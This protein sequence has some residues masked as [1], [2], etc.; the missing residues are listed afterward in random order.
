MGLKNLTQNST[1]MKSN[2][3]YIPW[4]REENKAKFPWYELEQQC[5]EEN[6]N[7]ARIVLPGEA[8][9]TLKESFSGSATRN[10]IH[11]FLSHKRNNPVILNIY[12]LSCRE[13]ADALLRLKEEALEIIAQVNF[14]H[15]NT[16]PLHSIK[17][18]DWATSDLENMLDEDEYLNGIP[19]KVF[20]RLMK[21]VGNS[22]IWSWDPVQLIIL[23]QKFKSCKI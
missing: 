10:K 7:F 18:M 20:E 3:I 17:V 4:Y 16:N 1:I 2:I 21:P 15:P 6:K 23:M 8:N 14:L 22:D 12:S 13:V 5:I 9:D 11:S 19:E